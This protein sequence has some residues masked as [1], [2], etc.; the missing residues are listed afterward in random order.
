MDDT[1]ENVMDETPGAE[2]AAESSAPSA[3]V[4]YD[5]YPRYFDGRSY[6]SWGD[7]TRTTITPSPCI[8]FV[9]NVDHTFPDGGEYT[10]ML[11]GIKS[12]RTYSA[13]VASGKVTGITS[14]GGD[15]ERITERMCADM[16]VGFGEMPNSVGTIEASGFANARKAYNGDRMAL[17]EGLSS[18]GESAFRGS[19]IVSF[20][21]IPD[22]L[23]EIGD[24]AFMGCDG[25]SFGQSTDFGNVSSIG[26]SAFM[27]IEETD[28]PLLLTDSARSVGSHAFSGSHVSRAY[29]PSGLSTVGEGVYEDCIGLE[30][31]EIADGVR[32]LGDRMFAN[33]NIVGIEF[34]E[35]MKSTGKYAFHGCV[36]L[37]RLTLPDS[38]EEISEGSFG[39]CVG[40]ES[41]DGGDGIK[42]VGDDAFFGCWGLGAFAYGDSL[43]SI[44]RHAFAATGFHSFT[45]TGNVSEAGEGCF[46]S[47]LQLE[48]CSFGG[49][50]A[51]V[52][53]KAFQ[54]CGLLSSVAFGDSVTS[55]GEWVFSGCENLEHVYFP[56][57]KTDV[58]SIDG[59]LIDEMDPPPSAFVPIGKVGEWIEAW[60]G[61]GFVVVGY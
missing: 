52:P 40:L 50:V 34:P 47:C 60:N 41:V 14:L 17:P 8:G 26:A 28:F 12:F 49:R 6:I 27:G 42:E 22:S 19:D 37:W 10:V 53:A 11:V 21:S 51:H 13:D 4:V 24:C 15:T 57:E 1:E 2:I 36:N 23:R 25:L 7:G 44:G 48:D 55:M 33:A 18:I 16:E 46:S 56:Q 3:H 45:V 5:V 29:V 20:S 9:Q 31:V 61:S 32:T 35:G 58:V 30:S 59:R 54:G 39:M 43:T 38:V